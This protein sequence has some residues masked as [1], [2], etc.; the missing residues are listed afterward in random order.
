MLVW[1]IVAD[2]KECAI[3]IR[4]ERVHFFSVG[5]NYKENVPLGQRS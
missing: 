4:V 2:A 3:K 1:H 5:Y